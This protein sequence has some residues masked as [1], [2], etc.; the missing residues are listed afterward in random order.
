MP[1]EKEVIVIF[2]AT[3]IDIE[4]IP[5]D[6][7]QEFEEETLKSVELENPSILEEIREKGVISDDNKDN[8]LVLI[9][10]VKAKYGA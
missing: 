6:K 9:K 4:E 2:A 8:L 7:M 10:K 5:M 3:N 1:I